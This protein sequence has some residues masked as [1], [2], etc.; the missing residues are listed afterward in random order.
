MVNKSTGNTLSIILC[1]LC[2]CVCVCVP[3][4]VH[5]TCHLA[6]LDISQHR[7]F[8]YIIITLNVIVH[9]HIDSSSMLSSVSPDGGVA[10]E[11]EGD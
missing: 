10:R 2:V 11:R 8:I 3:A 1:V 7:F 4:C 6:V 5:V 9:N